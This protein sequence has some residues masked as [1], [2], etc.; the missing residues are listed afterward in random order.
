MKKE[1]IEAMMLDFMQGKL[2]EEDKAAVEAYL[3]QQGYDLAEFQEL[4]EVW[5]KM[6]K[7]ETPAPSRKMR[8]QFYTNL[9]SF[10]QD[11]Q[12]KSANL[13]A[14]LKQAWSSLF[15]QAWIKQFAYG[16]SFLLLGALIGYQMRGNASLSRLENMATEMQ[17]MK[18]VMMLS[19]M[20]QESASKRIK[21]VNMVQG[22]GDVDDQIINTLFTSLN[23]DPN[24]NVRLVAA[25]ALQSFT[26]R[27][28]VRAKLIQAMANQDSPLVQLTLID[29]L[30]SL[31]ETEAKET[32][33]GLMKNELM[34]EEVR[35]KAA[36]GLGVSL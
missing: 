17:Q 14:Q 12:Q 27:P 35:R 9:A 10:K 21:A 6:E 2:P 30:L 32:L 5:E 8:D 31:P 4:S 24:I 7:L 20:E 15:E 28:T 13:F 1:E 34:N 18:K 33:E 16:I 22:L 36:R 29:V 3:A 25:E 26:E 19:M 23:E 11:E